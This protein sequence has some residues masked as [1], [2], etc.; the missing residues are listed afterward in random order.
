MDVRPDQRRARQPVAQ[1]QARRLQAR[2]R[3]GQALRR[4]PLNGRFSPAALGAA[5]TLYPCIAVL[6]IA[7]GFDAAASS[8]SHLT[9]AWSVSC[10]FWSLARC[11]Q[12]GPRPARPLRSSATRLLRPTILLPCAR[13]LSPARTVEGCVCSASLPP[14][15]AAVMPPAASTSAASRALVEKEKVRPRKGTALINQGNALFKAGDY[16]GAIGSYTRAIIVRGPSPGSSEATDRRRQHHLAAQPQPGVSQA[17]Q[18]CGLRAGLRDGA[19]ARAEERQG[20]LP[21]RT[22]AQGPRQLRGGDQGCVAKQCGANFADFEATLAADAANQ[23]AKDELEATQKLDQDV[24]AGL[25]RKAEKAAAVRSPTARESP[26]P[27]PVASTSAAAPRKAPKPYNEAPSGSS[28]AASLLDGKAL[29]AE[30]SRPSASSDDTL[31]RAVSTRK[32][33]ADPGAPQPS[34]FAA[35]RQAREAREARQRT[36]MGL[37]TPLAPPPR[38]T[39]PAPPVA[40]AARRQPSANASAARPSPAAPRP[41][42]TTAFDFTRAWKDRPTAADRW[43]LLR[44]RSRVDAAR[45]SGSARSVAMPSCRHSDPLPVHSIISVALRRQPRAR[46]PRAGPRRRRRFVRLAAS[47]LC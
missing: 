44:V 13:A 36:S 29:A 41:T 34:P 17:R 4:S 27:A 33:D 42:P 9:A 46:S 22:G 31:M 47:Q 45:C 15:W 32:L 5:S 14:S 30:S 26:A 10:A 21:P 18:V 6:S 2:D 38:D 20:A 35:A 39:P 19:R 28:T 24:K 23:P 3:Q 7:L 25:Q 16:V 37:R 43:A 40:E 12:L 1:G 8:G 11:K